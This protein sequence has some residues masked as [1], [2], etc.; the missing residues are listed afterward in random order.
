MTDRR[1]PRAPR[2]RR[3]RTTTSTRAST[4]P[5][6]Y[7]EAVEGFRAEKDHY[8][9][10]ARWQPDPGRGTRGVRG[11]SVLP[12]RRGPPLRGP[13]P[14]AVRRLR[15]AAV[16]DPDIGRAVAARPSRGLVPFRACGDRRSLAAYVI[17]HPARSTCTTT[18]DAR[19]RGGAP[20]GLRAVPRRDE[21]PRDLRRRPLPRPRTGGRRHVQPRLQPRLSP[22]VRLRH[23]VLVSADPGREPPADPDRGRRAAARGIR[24]G[25]LTRPG[26]SQAVPGRYPAPRRPR[27]ARLSNHFEQA[28]PSGA[29]DR[30]HDAAFH[31]ASRFACLE[32]SERPRAGRADLRP[33]TSIKA[34][35]TR[36]S[37]ETPPGP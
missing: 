9:K 7:A 12:G 18:P 19:G 13:D 34:G 10:H 16:P 36:T 27:Q 15:A 5:L 32:P 22:V 1:R 20:V 14:R 11:P 25:P 30:D 31:P 29:G 24:R 3:P 28:K 37:A 4:E 33:G 17:D 8:F 23:P 2:A 35:A 26:S 21:R 6:D